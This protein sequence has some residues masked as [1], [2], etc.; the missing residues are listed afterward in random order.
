[1]EARQSFGD[2][3]RT[4]AWFW[5]IFAVIVTLGII[6]FFAQDQ[7]PYLAKYPRDWVIPLR[8]VISDW[9]VSYTHLT[10]PTILRV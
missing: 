4:P 6:L 5:G 1:M 2:V 9:T 7:A 8:F 10:L 3:A